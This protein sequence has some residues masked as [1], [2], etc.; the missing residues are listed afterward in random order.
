MKQAPKYI[1]LSSTGGEKHAYNDKE[2]D[3]IIKN[4]EREGRLG[5][6]YEQQRLIGS[7]DFPDQEG[8]KGAVES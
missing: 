4:W 2:R 8:D 6:L 7:I 5:V 1:F 3:F